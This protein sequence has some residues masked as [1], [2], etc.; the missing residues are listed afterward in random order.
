MQQHEGS[1]FVSETDCSSC[2][3]KVLEFKYRQKLMWY[4]LGKSDRQR[5]RGSDCL[6]VLERY[7]KVKLTG[8]LNWENDF[9]LGLKIPGST[10]YSVKG[11]VSLK[12]D[13]R[14]R[15][16]ASCWRKTFL[17]I[18]L[19]ENLEIIML[20]DSSIGDQEYLADL[21]HYPLHQL[22]QRIAKQ[23]TRF[24]EFPMTHCDTSSPIK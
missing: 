8:V 1:C 3:P 2:L 9:A 19:Q 13:S 4:E 5:A 21:S 7:G 15:V 23:L 17:P 14:F 11:I 24:R 16:Q 18:I 20:L 6:W 12:V 22:K 10:W